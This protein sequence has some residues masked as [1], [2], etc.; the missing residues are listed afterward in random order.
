MAEMLQKSQ[1]LSPPR[2]LWRV[3][4]AP[5]VEGAP[6]FYCFEVPCQDKLAQVLRYHVLQGSAVWIWRL[7]TKTFASHDS[8]VHQQKPML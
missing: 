1:R 5:S 2:K 8:R 4:L 3:H 7:K 6:L